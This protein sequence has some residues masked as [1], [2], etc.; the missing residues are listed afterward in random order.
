MKTFSPRRA[1]RITIGTYFSKCWRSPIRFIV[2]A[3]VIGSLYVLAYAI[4]T[5]SPPALA[6]AYGFAGLNG[7]CSSNAFSLSSSEAGPYVSS[8]DTRKALRSDLRDRIHH[9]RW[10]VPITF[11][12]K[13]GRGYTIELSTCVSAAAW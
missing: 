13:N 8:V 3:I 10:C 11:D 1:R 12:C 2:A 9:S 7:A 5:H 4:A 6:A